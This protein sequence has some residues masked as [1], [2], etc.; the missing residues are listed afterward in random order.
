MINKTLIDYLPFL[1]SV[2]RLSYFFETCLWE[3]TVCL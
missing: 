3:G 2:V 1:K